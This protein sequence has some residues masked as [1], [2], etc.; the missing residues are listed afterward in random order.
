MCDSVLSVTAMM[1][2]DGAASSDDIAAVDWSNFLPLPA[3]DVIKGRVV[4]APGEYGW[5]LLTRDIHIEAG[6]GGV[7]CLLSASYVFVV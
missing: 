5:C 7:R 6:V 1:D 2:T 4:A 3:D